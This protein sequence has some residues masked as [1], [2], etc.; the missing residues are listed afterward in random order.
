LRSSGTVD[1]R[2]HSKDDGKKR[3]SAIFPHS[4]PFCRCRLLPKD[5]VLILFSKQHRELQLDIQIPGGAWQ[6]FILRMHYTS[7]GES[8]ISLLGDNIYFSIIFSGSELT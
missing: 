4:A 2:R 8:F 7:F 5:T 1:S 6:S 3:D